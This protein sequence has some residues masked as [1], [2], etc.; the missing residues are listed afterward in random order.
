MK[1]CHKILDVDCMGNPKASRRTDDRQ[2]GRQADRQTDRQTDRL[3]D[4]Q[5][6]S[7]RGREAD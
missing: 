5:A 4:R 1:T 2:L 3:T 6:D 7:Q